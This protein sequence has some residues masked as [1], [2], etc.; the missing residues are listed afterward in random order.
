VRAVPSPLLLLDGEGV[1]RVEARNLHPRPVSGVVE[2]GGS[3]GISAEPA[4]LSFDAVSSASTPSSDVR[5]T[6][7][8]DGPGAAELSLRSRL[9]FARGEYSVP[10]IAL[11]SARDETRVEEAEDRGERVWRVDNGRVSYAVRTTGVPALYSLRDASGERLYSAFPTPGP[12]L[13]SY[14]VYGGVTPVLAESADVHHPDALGWLKGLAFRAEAAERQ[15]SQGAIWRGVRLG[16]D[17]EHE[18]LLGLRFEIEYLTVLGS[19]VLAILAS[20]LSLGPARRISYSLSVYPSALPEPPALLPPDQAL[21]SQDATVAGHDMPG[22]TWTAAE[23]AATGRSLVLIN[24][25]G[26]GVWAQAQ[27]AEGVRLGAGMDA[28]APA[29]GE[30]R[31]CHYL[32]LAADRRQAELYASLAELNGL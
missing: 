14:P 28:V 20:A 31:A 21:L 12:L 4:A 27:G 25:L 8:G 13:W 16:A 9:P 10:V 29:G 19:D 1:A 22:R 23:Y 2:V 11:G 30:V 26:D 18:S 3:D 32:A 6:R 24:A 5:L 15:G 7:D 17:L